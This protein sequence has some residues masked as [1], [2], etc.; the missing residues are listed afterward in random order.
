MTI[1]KHQHLIVKVQLSE[2]GNA[3]NHAQEQKSLVVNSQI[4]L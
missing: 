4:N 3:S 1:E 2:R